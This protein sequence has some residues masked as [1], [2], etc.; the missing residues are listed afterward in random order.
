MTNTN[1]GHKVKAQEEATHMK[2]WTH[3]NSGMNI[4]NH[5]LLSLTSTK[6][7]GKTIRTTEEDHLLTEEDKP[8]SS[9]PMT[10]QKSQ[11]EQLVT[12][13]RHPSMVHKRIASELIVQTINRRKTPP[14]S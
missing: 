12:P 6:S 3:E 5:L 10:T 14:A 8:P 1:K 9:L 13:A 4:A 11:S 2:Q 7:F